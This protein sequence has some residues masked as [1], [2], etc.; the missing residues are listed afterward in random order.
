M[1]RMSAANTTVLV[2][3][4]GTFVRSLFLQLLVIFIEL[5]DVTKRTTSPTLETDTLSWSFFLLRCHAAPFS[6]LRA[7]RSLET[8][9]PRRI[10]Y[11]MI[12]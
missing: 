11:T 9:S 3:R 8:T 7:K 12:C 10:V 1:L 5:C 6:C 4:K 2:Q